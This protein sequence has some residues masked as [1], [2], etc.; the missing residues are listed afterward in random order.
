MNF[1]VKKFYKEMQ[2]DENFR[3]KILA[4]KKRFNY[5]KEPKE[6]VCTII[7]KVILPLSENKGYNFDI[8]D[9]LIFEE[10]FSESGANL[11]NEQALE[12]VSGG[13]SDIISDAFCVSRMLC[14]NTDNLKGLADYWY[15]KKN[16][17]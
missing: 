9:L 3:K 10:E 7:E 13:T 12:K 2:K 17:L 5:L 4:A 15:N 6:K 1:F 14:N 16:D 11:I 8:Y